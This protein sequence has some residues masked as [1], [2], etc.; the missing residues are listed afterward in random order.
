[1]SK[2]FLD[3]WIG[4]SDMDSVSGKSLFRPSHDKV[5]A[6]NDSTGLRLQRTCRGREFY[7][8]LRVGSAP[9]QW[10][11]MT[12]PIA[13]SLSRILETK[14]SG[15]INVSHFAFATQRFEILLLEGR[16]NSWAALSKRPSPSTLMSLFR[17]LPPL[18]RFSWPG[19]CSDLG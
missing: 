3:E 16:S 12:Y 6:W 17:H 14:R 11:V 7:L 19:H 9:P 8:A 18:T 15:Q 13:V 2:V 10:K 5:L 1:M 4:V